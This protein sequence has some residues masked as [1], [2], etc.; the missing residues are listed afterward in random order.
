MLS[1]KR[2]R[3]LALAFSALVLMA[4][5]VRFKG[6]G[7]NTHVNVS[8]LLETGFAAL[9]LCGLKM[10]R[11]TIY[12]DSQQVIHARIDS[13]SD[14]LLVTKKVGTCT[15]S[16]TAQCELGAIV[17]TNDCD[18]SL[19]DVRLLDT[20]LIN[21]MKSGRRNTMAKKSE[22][23]ELHGEATTQL[24]SFSVGAIKNVEFSLLDI[25]TDKQYTKIK[26]PSQDNASPIASGQ[27]KSVNV[28]A[29]TT[30]E[31]SSGQD[32]TRLVAI[33]NVQIDQYAQCTTI[34]TDAECSYDKI[35]SPDITRTD[36]R[37]A[38]MAPG[39]DIQM[40]TLVPQMDG[41]AAKGQDGGK[42]KLTCCRICWCFE[43][44]R[45]WPCTK[46]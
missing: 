28:H 14:E 26:F 33:P 17:V 18:S 8:G 38:D 31:V 7:A 12:D 1:A 9:N 30:P 4:S 5:C 32:K 10:L 34:Y 13:W 46:A 27:C 24:T 2:M 19:R 37:C 11:L 43:S 44:R 39:F 15:K 22:T 29:L 20:P 40:G 21:A 41:C 45:S 25:S 3:F 42:N 23:I 36:A 16:Y 35:N 6:P